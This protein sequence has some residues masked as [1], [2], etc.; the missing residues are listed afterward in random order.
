M[1][2]NDSRN[3]LIFI[4]IDSIFQKIEKNIL[5]KNQLI[6]LENQQVIRLN[7]KLLFCN[8]CI[9]LNGIIR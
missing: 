8:Y 6:I 1:I 3:N 7:Y 9:I 2:N 5:L 4:D